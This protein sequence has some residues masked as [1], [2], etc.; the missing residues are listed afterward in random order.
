M[1]TK[2]KTL[3]VT[4]LAIVGAVS[5]YMWLRKPKKND[6]GFYSNMSGKK[7][8][9]CAW[10]KDADGN[11]FHTGSDRNCPKSTRCVTSYS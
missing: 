7:I 9:T 2:T 4:G 11:V 5:V 8:G 6:D 3:L 1:N 10:C